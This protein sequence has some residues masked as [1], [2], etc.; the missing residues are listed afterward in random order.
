MIFVRFFYPQSSKFNSPSPYSNNAQ[1]YVGLWRSVSTGYFT[2]FA[3]RR[4]SKWNLQSVKVK[5]T[6][7][8]VTFALPLQTA[9][10][11]IGICSL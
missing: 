3:R 8:I 7:V 5:Q 4:C 10:T 1:M 9:E 6:V 2:H 11:T